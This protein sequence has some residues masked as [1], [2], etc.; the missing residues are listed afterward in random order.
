MSSFAIYNRLKDNYKLC[1]IEIK[2]EVERNR[3]YF[4]KWCKMFH[5]IANGWGYS[6]VMCENNH[7]DKL[8]LST[9]DGD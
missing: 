6:I 8:K 7:S 4:S 1:Y 3:T 2:E 5:Y 9:N